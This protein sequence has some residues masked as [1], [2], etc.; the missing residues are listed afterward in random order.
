MSEKVRVRGPILWVSIYFETGMGT[1]I[2]TFTAF[3]AFNNIE[4]SVM[5][6]HTP[7]F[8]RIKN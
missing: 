3:T 1:S 8:S 4:K 5:I 2:E 7:F 6:H